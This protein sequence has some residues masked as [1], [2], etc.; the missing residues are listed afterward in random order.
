MLVHVLAQA[1]S[2]LSFEV[3]ISC[4]ISFYQHIVWGRYHVTKIKPIC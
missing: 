4:Y 1:H 2:W 3:G